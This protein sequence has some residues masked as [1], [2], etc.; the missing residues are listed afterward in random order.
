MIGG[1]EIFGLFLPRADRIE[2]TEVLEDMPG[3]TFIDDPRGER[4][5]RDGSDEDPMRRKRPM[6]S[7][8][9][10]GARARLWVGMLRRTGSASFGRRA[11]RRRRVQAWQLRRW[12]SPPPYSRG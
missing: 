5:A 3:D 8:R 11:R 10:A 4:L 2:L 7:L 9:Y 6:R 12:Q 1:A